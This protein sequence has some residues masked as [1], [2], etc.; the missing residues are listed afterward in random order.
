MS[1]RKSKIS[2]KYKLGKNEAEKSPITFNQSCTALYLHYTKYTISLI[3]YLQCLPPPPSQHTHTKKKLWPIYPV[4]QEK[5]QQRS[6]LNKQLLVKYIQTCC[7][8]TDSSKTSSLHIRI[9]SWQ[10]CSVNVMPCAILYV[11]QT[12]S[13]LN[14]CCRDKIQ[15]PSTEIWGWQRPLTTCGFSVPIEFWQMLIQF[16]DLVYIDKLT[17]ITRNWQQLEK[18]M[19]ITLPSPTQQAF[20]FFASLNHEIIFHE[21]GLVYATF[22]QK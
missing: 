2:P 17:K 14:K 13:S 21:Y 9:P 12:V 20:I 18:L 3:T 10:S 19:A 4:Y 15:F 22:L 7:M 5:H 1:C 11:T 16:Q 6:D 8:P